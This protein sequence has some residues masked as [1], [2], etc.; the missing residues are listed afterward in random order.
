MAHRNNQPRMLRSPHNLQDERLFSLSG[1]IPPE[2]FDKL[3]YI[4]TRR[5]QSIALP[6][7]TGDPREY[8]AE[9]GRA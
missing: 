1:E 3:N 8:Y 5:G 6:A 4:S 2:H 7:P 9:P